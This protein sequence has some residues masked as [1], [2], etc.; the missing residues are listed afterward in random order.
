MTTPVDYVIR[1]NYCGCRND[2]EKAALSCGG[3]IPGML[4]SYHIEHV[5]V[6][7]SMPWKAT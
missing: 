3:V 7:Y 1:C 4:R 2:S 5:W 6:N